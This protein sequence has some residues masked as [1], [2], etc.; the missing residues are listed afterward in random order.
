MQIYMEEIYD[1]L[2]PRNGK[3]KIREDLEYG[4]TYVEDL[5]IVPISNYK[6]SVDLINAGLEYR[7]TG[8]QVMLLFYCR[9]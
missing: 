1:L 8:N 9:K 6:Q 3:L 7:K 5:I 2:N 4:E